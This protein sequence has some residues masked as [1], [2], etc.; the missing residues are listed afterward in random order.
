M[1]VARRGRAQVGDVA[2]DAVG[3][4]LQPPGYGGAG[5]VDQL[6][7]HGLDR[8]RAVSAD[9]FEH[10]GAGRV[11]SGQLRAEVEA[12]QVG[13]ARMAA[14]H[15]LDV[16]ADTAALDQLDRRDRGGL[17][18][19]VARLHAEAA[20]RGAADVAHVD[21]VEH[22]A[23]DPAVDE[24][25]GE[26][27]HVHL[28]AHAD[29]RIVLEEHVAVGDAGVIAAVFQRPA[30]HQVRHSGEI[31]DIGREQDRFAGLGLKRGV[32]VIGIDCDRRGG[33]LANRIG[34][35]FVDDPQRVAD[36]LEGDRVD[37]RGRLRCEA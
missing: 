22:P 14:D 3:Q 4:L 29:Q 12:E 17:A 23:E 13:D 7:H 9:H 26:G 21:R 30:D 1:A 36:D 18:I 6:A 33:H 37:L 2:P 25:R 31:L 35:L 15:I 11:N 27:L 16:A 8:R 10:A 19:H 5:V 28:M 32:E 34:L 20:G 24:H